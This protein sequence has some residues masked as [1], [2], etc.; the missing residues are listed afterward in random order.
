M[1]LFTIAIASLAIVSSTYRTYGLE[2]L[3]HAESS[4]DPEET[5]RWFDRLIAMLQHEHGSEVVTQALE[6][7]MTTENLDWSAWVTSSVTA[8]QKSLY[9]SLIRE[10]AVVYLREAL[11]DKGE[12]S[13]AISVPDIIENSSPYVGKI[14]TVDSDGMQVSTGSG[15][16]V[17]KNIVITSRHVLKGAADTLITWDDKSVSGVVTIL[18][19]YTEFS[20]TNDYPDIALLVLD[21]PREGGIPLATKPPRVGSRIITVGN[22]LGLG[23][24]A[25]EGII[26][27][28]PDGL[29]IQITAAVSP[30]SSGSPVLDEY[31][32]VIGVVTSKIIG[33]EMLNIAL[34]LGILD[35]TRH[36]M[37]SHEQI[38]RVFASELFEE[39]KAVRQKYYELHNNQN[40]TMLNKFP[41]VEESQEIAVV[42]LHAEEALLR[43]AVALDSEH[44]DYWESLAV[45]L[46]LQDRLEEAVIAISESIE[47]EPV[48]AADI[49]TWSE[50]IGQALNMSEK[51]IISW[52]LDKVKSISSR[53]RLRGNLVW[54]NTI[55]TWR[56]REPSDF[57]ANMSSSLR[58]YNQAINILE[59]DLSVARDHEDWLQYFKQYSETHFETQSVLRSLGDGKTRLENAL[60]YNQFINKYTTNKRDFRILFKQSINLAEIG[61][62]FLGK[63][64]YVKSEEALMQSLKLDENCMLTRAVMAE[65]YWTTGR[66]EMSKEQVEIL[67]AND[68]L[69]S[70]LLLHNLPS[71]I[72]RD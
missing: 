15:F 72:T 14:T 50:A 13:A 30:G 35:G 9:E 33:G 58:D 10:I 47:H 42:H 3:P 17:A 65:L 61:E 69:L 62:I 20:H 27:A 12:P 37:F 39:S 64:D 67:R 4:T 54:Q 36:A 57:K 59:S 25:S 26:S 70:Q 68:S 31:G 49:R 38:N 11:G 1:H 22:P 41:I 46:Q 28:V 51:S 29:R 34:S 66:I 16:Q 32:R 48:L 7:L 24:T 56:D 71:E 18:V 40:S 6:N 52:R 44:P 21:K 60:R 55:L 43:E 5:S 19:P 8:E 2:S 23:I 63:K 45:C 53:Y